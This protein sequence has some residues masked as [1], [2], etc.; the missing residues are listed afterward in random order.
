MKRILGIIQTIA[1]IVTGL[2]AWLLWLNM[3]TPAQK[4]SQEMTQTLNSLRSALAQLQPQVTRIPETSK[5]TARGLNDLADNL[6]SIGSQIDH[7]LDVSTGTV[8]AITKASP[9][10]DDAAKGLDLVANITAY[11]PGKDVLN[12]R[13]KLYEDA[14]NIRGLRKSVDASL[15]ESKTAVKEIKPQLRDSLNTT[16]HL[17]RRYASD[18]KL[19][20]SSVLPIIPPLL[21]KTSTS[22]AGLTESVSQASEVL[23]LLCITLGAIGIA[24]CC[25]GAARILS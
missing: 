9:A 14:K 12:E 10:L 13:T 25:S 3:V 15:L 24:F 17:L 21:E 23:K 2:A 8:E 4:R 7:L 11:I 18:L 5:V 1:G 22:V 19:M 16:A 20:E 6:I